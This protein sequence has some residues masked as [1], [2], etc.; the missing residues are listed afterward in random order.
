M[1]IGRYNAGAS[2]TST[3]N[4]STMVKSPNVP[5]HRLFDGVLTSTPPLAAREVPTTVALLSTPAGF[6][7]DG[8]SADPS[9][10]SWNWTADAKQR[11]VVTAAKAVIEGEGRPAL[12]ELFSNSPMWW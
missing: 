10:P 1:N 6:W 3:V 5:A 12:F 11:A 8:V 4:G 7:V 2:S 9:S